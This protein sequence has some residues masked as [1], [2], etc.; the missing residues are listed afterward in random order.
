[1]KH[2][3]QSRRRSARV[4]SMVATVVLMFLFG[5]PAPQSRGAD[6]AIAIS[7]V[8]TVA[9]SAS[10]HWFAAQAPASLRECLRGNALVYGPFRDGQSPDAGIYPTA[11]QIEEDLTFISQITKRIRIY[12]TKGPFALVPRLA[13]KLGIS[14]TQGIHLGKDQGENEEE[15][16]AALTLAHAGLIDSI[17]VGNEIL[18][19]S[20][21]PKSEL[22]SYIRRVRQDAP[23]HVPVSTAETWDK[24]ASNLDLAQDV[25]FVVAHFYPFWEKQPI[26]GATTSLFQRYRALENQLH[27]EYPV[28]DLKVVIGETG[29]PSGGSPIADGVIPGPQNQRRFVEEVMSVACESSIPFYFFEAFDEEW[30][31]QEG[32]TSRV[33]PQ[34]LPRDR[35]F[36]ANWVGS[37]WGIFRSNGRLKVHF[38]DMFYQPDPGT[39]LQRDILIDGQLATYYDVGV[40]SSH[41]R[42]DW[43]SSADRSLKMSYASGQDW[44]AVFV[45]VGKPSDPPRPWK[46]FSEFGILALD[47]R[48][49]NGGE[50]V[51]VGIKDYA[52]PDDG[53]ERKVRLLLGKEYHRYDIPLSSFASSRMV[54]PDDLKR[55][56]VVAEFVFTGREPQTVYVRNIRYKPA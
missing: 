41:R 44:G 4:A 29:W 9:N 53:S 43:L 16:A 18:T 20:R 27:S 55:L 32:F 23:A 6:L 5:F 42:R 31:W 1:M 28:R 52:A 11:V 47:L 48:G 24:W 25:D 40:D 17:I 56:Y 13:E 38:A 12:S 54:I 2:I 35:T 3:I 34:D 50:T 46:D 21:L 8:S 19:G 14:V 7:E 22:I 37:S 10:G 33:D 26:D 49:E 15:I 36:S 51:E 30:K 39:R 45:T